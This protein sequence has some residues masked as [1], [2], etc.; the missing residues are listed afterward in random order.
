MR[1]THAFP[2]AVVL[3][4]RVPHPKQRSLLFRVGTTT[5]NP[6]PA[7]VILNAESGAA[8]LEGKDLHLFFRNGKINVDHNDQSYRVGT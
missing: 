8:G 3:L 6:N 5:T 1:I 2:D 7:H 4:P